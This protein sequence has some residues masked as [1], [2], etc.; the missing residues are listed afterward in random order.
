M[1]ELFASGRVV[2]LLL[3][4]LALEA[5]FISIHHART[6]RG[7]GLRNV[8]GSLLAGAFLMFALRAALVGDSWRGIE[9]WLVAAL[10]VHVADLWQ[11]LPK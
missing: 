11:R 8:A 1:S 5:A 6:R 7:A 3:A 2:D 9:P 10:I 4:L